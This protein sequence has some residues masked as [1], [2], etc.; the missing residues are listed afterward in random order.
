MKKRN[1]IGLSTTFHDPGMAIVNSRGEIVFA[2][3]AER[4]L[5]NKRAYYSP[6]IDFIRTQ[7]IIENYCEPDADLVLASTWRKS[8][9]RFYKILG[10]LYPGRKSLYDLILPRHLSIYSDGL[11]L[12][13][14][15]NKMVYSIF[16]HHLSKISPET[17]I[18]ERSYNHH[19]THAFAACTSSPFE[20]AVCA[21]FDSSGEFSTTG[22]FHYRDGKIKRLK[23]KS[24]I[25]SL[26]IY[27]LMLCDA[28]GFNPEKG[29]EWKVMGLAAYGK[30]D[31]ELYDLIRPLFKVVNGRMVS[32]SFRYYKKAFNKIWSMDKIRRHPSESP[33]KAADLAYTGQKIFCEVV[34]EILSYL[35]SLKVSK[36]LVL[37]GGCTLNSACNGLILDNVPFDKLYVPP[38]PS[39]DGNC[40]GAA[41]LAYTEDHP[42]SIANQKILS[43]YLGSE[44]RSDTMHR[45]N[46]FGH[47]KT[48]ALSPG[49][50]LTD[51]VAKLISDG[52]IVG[53]I[54]GKA[55]FGPRALG[56]RSILA[57][58][59]SPQMKERINAEIKFREAFRPFAPSILHEFGH[60]Y[61]EN[62]QESPYME[63]TL[64]FRHE[65]RNKVPAVVHEDGTGRLQSVKR[66]W[67][68]T[69]Y[70]L[71]YAFYRQTGVPILLNT[72]FNIMGK[73][74]VHSVEDALAVFFTS[75]LNVLVVGDKIFIKS[76][77]SNGVSR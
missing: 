43:P 20:E 66:E 37:S 5:Q 28:C 41:R 30:F 14:S 74:I 69:Y 44:I 48:I 46:D 8:Y 76:G 63:R 39:D 3:A 7:S 25:A 60:E 65:V 10:S 21:V 75:G 34:I 26:G 35:E 59:R 36:N 53:W 17:R 13:P 16:N 2:E 33:L 6:S 11:S 56:N 61:F 71:I 64:R 45:L 67:N 57:D 54:Q 23:I 29:E 18:I 24:S 51:R 55:E 19:H 73:P 70:D 32:D 15:Y 38:A 58:P 72:S 68:E 52:N 22:F 47:I 77:S 62:Y 12:G 40:I 9:L 49:E 4:Y 27:Y 42:D 1:Y 50:K 31:R